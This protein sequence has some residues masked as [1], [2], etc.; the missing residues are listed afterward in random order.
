MAIKENILVDGIEVPFKASAAVPR[1]YRIKFG[2]DIYRDFADLQKS[3][4]ENSDAENSALSIESLEVFENIAYIMAKHADPENVPNSPDEWL[5]NFNTFSIYEILP[6]LLELW[7]L[8]IETQ[9][10]SK[11]NIAR[12]TGK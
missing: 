10:E 5:E 4:G 1:L 12:L 7:G 8:N 3:V 6:K 9:V 11:K 2:R